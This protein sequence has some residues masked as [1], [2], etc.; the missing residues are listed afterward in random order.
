ML[1][2]NAKMQ[3][4]NCFNENGVWA[5]VTVGYKQVFQDCLRQELTVEAVSNYHLRATATSHIHACSGLP[6][7]CQAY[8]NLDI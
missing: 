1:P 7:A 2:F 8:L 5:P 6:I 3:K 4:A